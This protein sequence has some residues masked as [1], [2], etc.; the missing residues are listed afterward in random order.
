LKQHLLIAAG[1][2]AVSW[3][4]VA[5]AA[6]VTYQLD[7]SHTYPSFE[8]DHMGGLSKWR[9]KF[10]KSAGTV[11][12]DRQAKTGT[13]NVTTQIS[14]LHTGSSV[15]D[16]YLQGTVFFD[17]KRYATAT[18]KGDIEFKGDTPAVVKGTLTLHGI[19]KPLN[20]EIESF[21]CLQHPMFKKEVCGVDAKAEFNRADFGL[22]YGDKLGFDMKTTL[23]ITAEWLNVSAENKS[24]AGKKQ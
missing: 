1:A 20:L 22:N 19:S 9:G 16:K 2:L 21:K 5:Q 12:L 11:T 8:A 13:V 10:D 24:P 14:S 3:S 18:Y 15:L 6:P 23:L 17:A 7:P 4:F